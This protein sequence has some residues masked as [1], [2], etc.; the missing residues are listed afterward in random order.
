MSTSDYILDLALIG[1]VFLQLRGRRLTVRSLLLPIGIVAYFANKYLHGIPTGGNS[2]TLVV[3][4][5]ALGLALGAGAGIYTRVTRS[6]DGS[7]F[8][9]AGATAAVLW[10]AG[11][12]TRFAFQFYA[13]HGGGAGIVRF[14]TQHHISIQAWTAALILMAFGEVVARTAIIGWRAFGPQ[15]AGG[16]TRAESHRSVMMGA[17]DRL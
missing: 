14:S 9:R 13:S 2:L 1:V 17:S 11:V 12:G 15:L 5:A 4:C 3:A 10:I 6:D 16:A 7:I 8:A